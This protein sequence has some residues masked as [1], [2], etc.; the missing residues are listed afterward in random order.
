MPDRATPNPLSALTPRERD[1]L[2][3]LGQD[4]S[5]G[6]IAERLVVSP[7][8]VKWYLKEIYSKLGVHSRD[9]ALARVDASALADEADAAPARHNLPAQ[10]TLLIGR[11]RELAA[12]RALL[13]DPA[14]RLVTLVGPPGIGK[15][16]LSVEAAHRLASDFPD[17]MAFVPLA[18][19]SDPALVADTIA[20]AL[21]LDAS[22]GVPTVDRLQTFLKARRALLVLDNFEHLLAA[23]P[24]IGELLAAAP[25]VKALAT[26]REPLRLYGEREYPVPAL[27][28]PTDAVALFTER[29]QAVRPDFALTADNVVT[30][31]A[32][33]R[34]LD[35]LPLAIE[36]AA[37]RMR[38][39]TPHAL[40][41][42]LASR[43]NVLTGGARD[44]SPRHQTLRAAIA[45][46]VDLLTADEQRL[47]ARFSVFDGGASVEAFA[48]VCGFG[49]ALDPY[50]GLESLVSKSLIQQTAGAD[51]EP[52]FTMYEALIEFA[53][54]QLAASGEEDAIRT[55]HAH[56][57]LTLAAAYANTFRMPDELWGL[58]GF[59]LEYA[60][61]RA[62]WLFAAARPEDNLI[63]L[64]A[65]NW[66]RL[67]T[68]IGRVQDG[69]LLYQTALH[70][71]IEDDTPVAADL[72]TGYAALCCLLGDD[73]AN[74]R[75]TRRALDIYERLDLPDGIVKALINLSFDV[76]LRADP[77]ESERLHRRALDIA[78]QRGVVRYQDSLRMNLAL[79]EFERGHYEHCRD[80]IEAHLTDVRQRGI[81]SAEAWLCHNLAS[82]YVALSDLD[83]A[84][85]SAEAGLKAAQGLT[86]RRKEGDLCSQ[87]AVLAFLKGDLER[88]LEF[89][90]QTLDHDLYTGIEQSVRQ[91]HAIMAAIEA[92]LGHLD[93]AR[94]HWVEVLQEFTAEPVEQGPAY[95]LIAA[96]A[97]GPF[98]AL[99][100]GQPELAAQIGGAI[101]AHPQTDQWVTHIVSAARPALVAQLGEAAFAAAWARGAAW[102][103][104]EL[105][106]AARRI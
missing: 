68:Q 106:A 49:L 85:V 33:C 22:A 82:V 105:A 43:L 65:H 70:P 98:V 63:S 8:T 102:S 90:R 91:D 53:A 79:V 30:V 28:I 6:E 38:L 14:V 11:G 66:Y 93:D 84:W 2:R 81:R 61:I 17:G 37:A 20:Q 71:R 62:A 18:P 59:E 10:A 100:L 34:R 74:L 1:I 101:N 15:T 44:L 3:L 19:L 89:M 16:R 23:A 76:S 99:A 24:L 39:N 36:L 5:G 27:D 50:D 60:N 4:L 9:E 41:G 25:G 35:G 47:F 56:R 29:A 48:A 51:G 80:L 103:L 83:S 54:E 92:R 88:A 7:Q 104:D 42:R 64:A 67:Y 32:I 46:S 40:L 45:W 96:A 26:S 86:M 97:P 31:T 69:A 12:L 58:R 72:M 52:R 21:G 57:Y 94:T 78:E 13:R 55:V 95:Q 75:L 77:D 87:L 73:E